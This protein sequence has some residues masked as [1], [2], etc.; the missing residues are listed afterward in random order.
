MDTTTRDTT[1]DTAARYAVANSPLTAVL[2][3]VPAEA[4]T[5]PSP[6]DGWL[7][8]DV[9]RHLVETQRDFFA[10][11]DVDLGDAPDVDA[12]P[13]GA[14]RAH[15]R[16]VAEVLADPALAATAFDGHFGPTTVGATLRQFYVWDMLVHRWDVATAT[17]TDAGLT[18]AELD[19]VEEGSASFGDALHMDGICAPE[20]EVATTADRA[21]RVLAR[22]GRRA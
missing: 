12:D 6:C 1:T 18:D 17:G 8:R 11:H 22:L 16:R 21:T 15:S 14:W 7:A 3:A 9:V 2:D 4:W 20:I 5:R 13:A 19:D 10:R